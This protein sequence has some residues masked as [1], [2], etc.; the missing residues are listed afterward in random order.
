[1]TYVVDDEPKGMPEAF[2]GRVKVGASE[3]RLNEQ[4]DDGPERVKR[5]IRSVQSNERLDEPESHHAQEL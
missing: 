3:K 1:M 2:G 5:R 4:V